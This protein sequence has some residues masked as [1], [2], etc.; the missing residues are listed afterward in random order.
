MG[1]LTDRRVLRLFAALAIVVFFAVG[2]GDAQAGKWKRKSK[3]HEDA[4]KAWCDEHKP[5][6]DHCSTLL[7]CGPGYDTIQSWTGYGKNWHACKRRPTR[8]E[9]SEQNKAE[10]EAYC[11]R[12]DDCKKCEWDRCRDGYETIKTFGGRGHNYHAC[13]LKRYNTPASNYNRD[14]CFKWCDENKPLCRTCY[15]YKGCSAGMVAIKSWA[16]KGRNFYAC[17]RRDDVKAKNKADCEAWCAAHEKCVK[18]DTN[19][20][21]GYGYLHMKSF[22]LGNVSSD[23][24]ACKRRDSAWGTVN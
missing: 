14:E 5:D 16:G 22:N 17:A 13:G 20:A 18:C 10:C 15:T 9:A 24:H 21:C 3:E 23:Y 11:A 2:A 7:N 19:K 8:D 4:C 1:E 6:C 12:N